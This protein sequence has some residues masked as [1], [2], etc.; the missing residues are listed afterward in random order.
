MRFAVK[1]E[2]RDFFSKN[3]YIECE[4]LLSLEQLALLQQEIDKT[5]AI[6]LQT[7][8]DKLKK[9]IVTVEHD[10]RPGR[11]MLNRRPSREGASWMKYDD[12]GSEFEAELCEI[13]SHALCVS[14]GLR[15]TFPAE[16]RLL[17]LF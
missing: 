8:P 4:D 10:G 3:R 7:T 14:D 17:Y 16:P 11:L 15:V 2:H 6:R 5:L 1:L 13:A 9:A 12:D